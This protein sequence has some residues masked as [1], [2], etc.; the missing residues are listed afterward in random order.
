MPEPTTPIN[1]SPR[2]D[3]RHEDQLRPIRFQN[4]IAPYAA[5]STLVEWGNT[6]VICAVT[7]EETIPRWMKE[8]GVAG[9]WITAEY[10][11]LP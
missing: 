1:P 8:Q 2:P 4:G 3:G 6:R 7:V 11:M 10:A 5:G 9:G